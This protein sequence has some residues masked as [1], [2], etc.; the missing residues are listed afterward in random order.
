[1]DGNIELTGKIVYDPFSFFVPHISYS[2]IT[3]FY[4]CL[5]KIP[6][7]VPFELHIWHH[8]P[9]IL[10][11]FSSHSEPLKWEKNG[12]RMVVDW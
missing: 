9:P 4:C 1:M 12:F 3:G 8:S 2:N 6:L 5:I 7:E 11:P 10:L